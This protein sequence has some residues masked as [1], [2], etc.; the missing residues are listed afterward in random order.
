MEAYRG[1]GAAA[2]AG[3]APPWESRAVE[4]L[5]NKVGRRTQRGGGGASR[6]D[7]LGAEPAAAEQRVEPFLVEGR[8][9]TVFA[10]VGAPRDHRVATQCMARGQ[11]ALLAAKLAKARAEAPPS[12]PAPTSRRRT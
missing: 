7:V 9:G 8:H 10:A 2:R 6:G 11:E 5:V 1:G 4:A 12:C 3:Q